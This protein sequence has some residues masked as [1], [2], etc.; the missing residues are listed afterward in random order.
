MQSDSLRTDIRKNLLAKVLQFLVGVVLIPTSYALLYL[1]LI[2]IVFSIYPEFAY[3]WPQL[4]GITVL[5]IGIS[6]ELPLI[7]LVILLWNKKRWVAYG[8]IVSRSVEA[9]SGAARFL[10][11]VAT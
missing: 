1:L 6:S 3:V 2:Q 4:S 11:Y 7:V 9:L 8:I 10:A 5:M